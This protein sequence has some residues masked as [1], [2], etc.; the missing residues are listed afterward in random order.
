MVLFGI[1]GVFSAEVTKAAGNETL[2][3]SPNCGYLLLDS[4][5]SDLSSYEALT[6]L[7]AMEA[8]DTLAASAYS[9]ACYGKSLS[10][11]QCHRYPKPNIPWTNKRNVPCH[12]KGNICKAGVGGFEMDTGLIDSLK[13]LGI[14]SKA[15][16]AVQYRK[17]TS[18]SVIR[19]KEYSYEYNSTNSENEVLQL[20]RYNYERYSSHPNNFTYQYNK[21]NF[22]G[23]NSYTLM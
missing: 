20:I 21:E 12:F 10:G 19:T 6:G 11:L 13:T 2:I 8:N 15:S 18:C 23:Q 4:N 5:R 7:T 16:E 1:A 22:I 3:R 14:N 17:V 9:R